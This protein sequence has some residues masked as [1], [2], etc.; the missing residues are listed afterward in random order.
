MEIAVTQNWGLTS[1][2]GGPLPFDVGVIPLEEDGVEVSVRDEAVLDQ[3]AVGFDLVVGFDSVL[4]VLRLEVHI[5]QG[6]Q[7]SELGCNLVKNQQ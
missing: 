1:P 4:L 3:L 7:E 2:K 6:S 5:C